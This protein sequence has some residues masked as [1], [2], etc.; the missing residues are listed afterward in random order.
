MST[1][2]FEYH[3]FCNDPYSLICFHDDDYFC[4]CDINNHTECSRYNSTLDECHEQCLANGQCLHGDLDDQK[5]FL[6]LCPRC[7]YGSVCQ[8]N[9]QLFSFTLETLLT[10]DLNSS[11]V[12][13]QQLFAW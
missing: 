11:S 5:D 10:N 4:L 1:I 2:I 3:L 8:H 13:I 7:Y 6:C 9:T 12:V